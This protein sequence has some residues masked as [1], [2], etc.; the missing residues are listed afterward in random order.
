M[1]SLN[2]PEERERIADQFGWDD[3]KYKR[4]WRDNRMT[5]K[6]VNYLKKNWVMITIIVVVLMAFGIIGKI[7]SKARLVMNVSTGGKASKDY[8]EYAIV[9]HD[10]LVTSIFDWFV[11]YEVVR[12]VISM[13]ESDGE[14]IQLNTAYSLK[15]GKD[16]R[17]E[18]KRE[19]NEKQYSQL[20]YK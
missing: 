6:F 14:F 8:K 11:N 20:K 1:S 19:L 15:Y 3:Y 16:L 17:T 10:A 4:N 7:I 13:M 5:R 9:L 2:F 12:N 18:L